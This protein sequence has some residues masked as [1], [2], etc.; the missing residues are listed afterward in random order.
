[1]KRICLFAAS[2]MGVRPSYAEAAAEFGRTLALRGIGLVY[3]GCSVGLMGIAADAALAAGGEVIGVIPE[4]LV[5]LEIAHP[6]LAELR[7]VGS[8]H[9]RK[10]QMAELSDGFAALPGGFGTM[11]EMFEILTW[12]QL[13]FHRKPCGFIN[14]DGY[15]DGLLSFLDRCVAEGLL[16]RENR[17]TIL[18]AAN[19][20][21]LLGAFESYEPAEAKKWLRRLKEL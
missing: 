13:G 8:M 3:G 5:E 4:P 18:T 14:I 20:E 10:A 11:D 6:G 12:S 17:Q 7:I 19:T 9:E 2:S 1:M 15:Y 16:R 21:A